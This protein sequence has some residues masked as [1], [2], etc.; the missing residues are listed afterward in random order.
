MEGKKQKS[1]GEK[2]SEEDEGDGGQ[3]DGSMDA[4]WNMQQ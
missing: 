1:G 2:R 3:T 4:G